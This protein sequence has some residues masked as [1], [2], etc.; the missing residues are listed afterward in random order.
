MNGYNVP[1][2]NSIAVRSSEDSGFNLLY[3]TENL[4]GSAFSSNGTISTAKCSGESGNSSNN[5]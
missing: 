5:I 1:L 4:S 2:V 3:R